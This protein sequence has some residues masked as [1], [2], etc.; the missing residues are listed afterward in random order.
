M[1]PPIRDG[2]GNS[3]G[4]IRLGDGSEI[5][6]VRTGAG[7]VL[8]SAIPDSTIHHWPIDAG[9][10]SNLTDEVGN[11]DATINGASWVNDSDK[12]S[13]LDFNSSNNEDVTTDSNVSLDVAGSNGFTISALIK[14]SFGNTSNTSSG[15]FRWIDGGNNNWEISWDGG[16]SAWRWGWSNTNPISDTGHSSDIWYSITHTVDTDGNH[17]GY[18][19]TQQE[20]T[21]SFGSCVGSSILYIGS[22]FGSQY[23]DGRITDVWI[24]DKALSQSELKQFR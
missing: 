22:R 23:W 4:S 17:I 10:G 21:G 6:E 14:P 9:S 7:D 19:N 12:G 3:I 5:S 16:A 20:T 11:V 24:C 15:I 2:S 13:V 1:S 18:L 8:F